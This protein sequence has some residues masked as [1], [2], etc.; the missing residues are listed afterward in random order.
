MKIDGNRLNPET[1][2]TGRLEGPQADRPG[3]TGKSTGGGADHVRV[4]SDGQLAT[5][6][7]A[8][9]SGSPDIRHDKVASARKALEAG[10]VGSD[11]VRLADK[12]IDSL[13]GR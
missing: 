1:V 5:A 3:R 4:S 10:T 2:T 12:L 6:A 7:A 9:V 8:A 11:V 13:L